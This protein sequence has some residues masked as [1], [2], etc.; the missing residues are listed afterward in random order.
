MDFT[1]ALVRAIVDGG[2]PAYLDFLDRGIPDEM[3]EGTAKP[4]LDFLGKYMAQYGGLPPI[5]VIEGKLGIPLPPNPPGTT[6]AFWADEILTNIIAV[7]QQQTMEKMVE[8][9][10]SNQILSSFEEMQQAV[11]RIQKLQLG[12]GSSRITSLFAEG[13]R[14][15][16]HYLKMKSGER[17]ILTPWSTINETTLGFNPEELILF[18]A[19]SGI[20]KTWASLMLAECAWKGYQTKDPSYKPKKYRVLYVTT[21]MS[22]LRIAIRFFA[23]HS[24]LPY[25]AVLSGQLNVFQEQ[26]LQKYTTDLL[27]EQ[28]LDIIG[29]NFDFRIETLAAAIDEH[30]PELVIIDGIYLIQGVPGKDRI[31]KA[32]NV[33]G[34]VKRLCMSKKVP[35][36]VTS[37][38]NREVKINEAKTARAES[39]AL[40]DAAV[41]HSTL[42]FGMVQTEDMQHDKRMLVKMMK[43]RDGKPG[44]FETNWDFES[45][46]FSELPKTKVSGGSMPGSGVGDAAEVDAALS[47]SEGSTTDNVPF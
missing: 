42:I 4:A 32:A 3:L 12:G 6:A 16:E 24:K 8:K 45:M 13:P 14:V 47:G 31:E 43:V 38:F 33:F 10:K 46:N 5:E 34:D 36:I 20:G 40:T 15:W 21:E 25:G 9:I 29:G 22:K 28:G 27:K 39:V 11:F 35:I 1:Q 7:E 23:L 17:G 30:K 44:D 18:V 26:K 19:R 37:Q 2:K 41:W